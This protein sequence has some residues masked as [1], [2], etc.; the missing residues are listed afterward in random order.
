MCREEFRVVS[1]DI[2]EQITIAVGALAGDPR[3][4]LARQHTIYSGLRCEANRHSVDFEF[5]NGDGGVKRRKGRA[6]GDALDSLKSAQDYFFRQY[7]GELN[8][9]LIMDTVVLIEPSLGPAPSY[10]GEG[11]VRTPGGHVYPRDVPGKMNE[12]MKENNS[13]SGAVGKAVHSHFHIARI[14]PF[15]NGNGRLA[16]LV[17][18]GILDKAGLP[19]IIVDTH[20]RKEYLSLLER[21]SDSYSEHRGLKSEQITFYNY[22]AMKLA[23]SLQRVKHRLSS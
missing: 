16:R 4:A 15:V 19:P 21:A 3:F 2:L 14:H 10:R 13:L 6:K 8:N 12:F 9:D 23:G 17:Q 22:L 1:P 5:P 18:N 11:L 20:E 7:V